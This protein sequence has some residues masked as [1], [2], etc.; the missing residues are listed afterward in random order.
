MVVA[1]SSSTD[2]AGASRIGVSFK[3]EVDLGENFLSEVNAFEI[4]QSTT[5]DPQDKIVSLP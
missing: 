5:I 2:E 4:A 1:Y 3:T